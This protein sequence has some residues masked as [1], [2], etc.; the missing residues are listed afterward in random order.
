MNEKYTVRFEEADDNSA[1]FINDA[2]FSVLRVRRIGEHEA[3]T[4]EHKR[5]LLTDDQWTAAL[6][7]LDVGNKVSI[8]REWS[9]Q[10][11][12]LLCG[13]LSAQEIRTVR[14]VLNFLSA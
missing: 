7:C 3:G 1:Y 8:A 9:D 12:R 10:Q 13:E 11:L 2:G 4:P 6:K 5:Q 14:A